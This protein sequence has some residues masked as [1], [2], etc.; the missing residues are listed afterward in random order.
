MKQFL[1]GWNFARVLRLVLAVAFLGAAVSTGEWI[2]GVFGAVLALQAM[3]NVGCC[4]STCTALPNRDRREGVEDV[5]YEE[6]R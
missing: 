4:G 5:H 6:V 3:L 2:A 1:S